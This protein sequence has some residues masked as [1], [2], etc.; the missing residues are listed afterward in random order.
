[1]GTGKVFSGSAAGKVQYPYDAV[2]Y[3]DGTT[4][5][6]VDSVGNV[7]AKGVAGVDDATVINDA[8]TNI[9]DGTHIHLC[10]GTYRIDTTIE[11]AQRQ[12]ISGDGNGTLLTTLKP[13]GG[14][15]TPTYIITT[16]SA[17]YDW[18]KPCI[19]EY[20]MTQGWSRPNADIYIPPV[21]PAW[22]HHIVAKNPKSGINF[23]GVGCVGN[24]IIQE[25][26]G[27]HAMVVAC[28]D[29]SFH[30]ISISG[31]TGGYN[32]YVPDSGRCLFTNIQLNTAQVG[33]QLYASHN[34]C[35]TNLYIDVEMYSGLV[36]LAGCYRNSFSN[37]VIRF[38]GGDYYHIDDAGGIE[39]LFTNVQFSSESGTKKGIR[40]GTNSTYLNVDF[41]GAKGTKITEYGLGYSIINSKGYIPLAD[42]R[43]P[44]ERAMSLMGTPALLCPCV[45]T[46]GTGITDY[47]RLVNSLT[48]QTSV[49][50][51]VGFQGRATYYDLNGTSHY[52]YKT[53]DTDFTFGN[54][55]SDRAFTTT[56]ALNADS[57]IS[58]QIMGKWDNNSQRE[59]RVFLDASGYLTF[60]LYDES[61]DKYIGRQ[62]TSALTTSTWNIITTTYDGTG[63]CEGCHIYL[64]G[65]QVDNA[66]YENA[67]YI[68]MQDTTAYFMVGALKNNTTYSEYY[69]GKLTWLGIASREF[70]PDEALA[71]NHLL[72]G[73]LGV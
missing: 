73:L 35:W 13:T 29:S 4:V 55:L 49:A 71:L 59:W 54:S 15:Y 7:I 51:W 58:A 17:G 62:Y 50:T 68:A 31:T 16:P 70:D 10:S 38:P 26:N 9:G 53:D 33:V 45:E 28:S 8:I 14:Y 64:N 36:L 27:G 22:I 24:I 6:A 2:V 19:I 1:M 37:V 43:Y 20:L 48:A 39:S 65:V 63:D 30:D 34:T 44:L 60:Q 47:T 11:L 12:R 18:T 69:D 67:G 5:C 32:M 72:K 57:V 61:V 40:T 25:A 52:L 3:I 41:T 46:T 56:V 42:I 66:D 21:S 23:K